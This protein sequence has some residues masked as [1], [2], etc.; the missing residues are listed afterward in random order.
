MVADPVFWRNLRT[1]FES[2]VTPRDRKTVAMFDHGNWTLDDRGRFYSRFRAFAKSGGASII[3]QNGNDAVESWLHQLR[4]RVPHYWSGVTSSD[5]R[6]TAADVKLAAIIQPKPNEPRIPP[7]PDGL[8][9]VESIGDKFKILLGH[10]LYGDYKGARKAVVPC[11]IRNPYTDAGGWIHDLRGASIELC[12]QLE[13]DAIAARVAGGAEPSSRVAPGGLLNNK[14]AA[15]FLDVSVSTIRR[16]QDE[17][18]LRYVKIGRDRRVS[19][20]DLIEIRD[21][22]ARRKTV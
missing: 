10:R 19:K 12:E 20:A 11:L 9:V 3:G 4:E 7:T 21:K 16:Y 8:M 18:V 17:G 5:F 1:D 13:S 15:T 22:G 6:E 2:L 14:K